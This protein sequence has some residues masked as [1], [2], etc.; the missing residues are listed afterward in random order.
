MNHLYEYAK[1]HITE[2]TDAT[3]TFSAP[4]DGVVYI[5]DHFRIKFISKKEAALIEIKS[6]PFF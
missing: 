1:Q 6:Q 4:S 3:C 2:L 5:D